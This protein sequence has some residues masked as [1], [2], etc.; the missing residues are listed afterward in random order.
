MAHKICIMLDNSGPYGDHYADKVD[1]KNE[2][3]IQTKK[4]LT[5]LLPRLIS[6]H[7]LHF[8][9]QQATNSGGGGGV[10]VLKKEKINSSSDHDHAILSSFFSGQM[11]RLG[12]IML[13]SELLQLG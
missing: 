6:L 7:A 4:L 3:C 2:I 5:R 8:I 12:E 10:V 9:E 11:V 1:Q 13:F